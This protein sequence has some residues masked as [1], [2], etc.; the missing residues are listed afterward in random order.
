M[1]TKFLT[2]KTTHTFLK[3]PLHFSPLHTATA[4][5]KNKSFAVPPA[6]KRKSFH[7]DPVTIPDT[8]FFTQLKIEENKQFPRKKRARFDY[9]DN[10][11]A[12][13]SLPYSTELLAKNQ[14]D[15]NALIALS[16]DNIIEHAN[17]RADLFFYTLIAYYK[18]N[19]FPTNGHTNLQHGRGRTTRSNITITEACHSSFTP[20]LLDNNIYQVS[21]VGIKRKR[22]LLSGTQLMES[23]NA[24]VELPP[25]VNHFDDLLENTCR[26]KCMEIL[27]DVSLGT[28]NPIEGLSRFL[29]M[30]SDILNDLKQNADHKSQSA[31]SRHSL[32]KHQTINPK[33]IDLVAKGTLRTTFS[34]QTETVTDAYIQLLLRITPIEKLC[35]ANNEQIEKL[36]MDKMMVMQNEILH[37]ISQQH[38]SP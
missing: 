8:L 3:S 23:L 37:T 7:A 13:L 29:K 33:L 15:L 35:C 32:M 18:T 21:K 25:F 5:V 10:Y 16:Q 38:Q 9:E 11:S 27:C 36:Y 17:R 26:Q 20:S 22:S 12:A 30:M 14:N 1:F 4:S 6:N 28:L 19:I 34:K 24:T 2:R 31:L